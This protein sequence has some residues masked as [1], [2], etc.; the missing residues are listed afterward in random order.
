LADTHVDRI[1]E[2]DKERAKLLDTAKKEALGRAQQ[3][4]ADLSALGF[5]YRLVDGT[6][7]AA[8]ASGPSRKGTRTIRDAPCPI[9]EFKTRPAHDARKHRFSQGKKKRPFTAQELAKLGMKKA[10]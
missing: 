9:C 6:T 8:R 1:K 4:V 3:A 7:K 2:L 10:G 5:G